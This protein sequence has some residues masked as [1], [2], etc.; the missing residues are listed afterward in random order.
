MIIQLRP[1]EYEKVGDLFAE[2]ATYH[3]FATAV[4]HH[5]LPGRI[6][7]DDANAPKSAFM[8]TKELQF[9]A[10]HPDNEAF[11]GALKQVLQQ[12]IF[13]GDG[14]EGSLAEIDLTF[15]DDSWLHR[16]ET[17]F[18]DWRWPP[19]PNQTCH[20]LFKQ[21]RLNWQTF[22]PAGYTVRPLD[23]AV[24]AN[25]PADHFQFEVKPL[26]QFGARDFG[27]CAVRH[28]QP[29]AASGRIVCLCSTDVISGSACEI[30]IETHPEH[31]RKGLATVTAAATVE[32]ALAHG[33]TA[34]WWICS[35]HNP[36]SI[37]TAEKVGFEKQF[38]SKGY[39]F[40]LDEAEHNRQ[41]HNRNE[42]KG[43]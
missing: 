9:L 8:S 6:Y 20:Y 33:F 40:L 34:I 24:I 29:E 32:Y 37:R 38:E 21:R 5:D 42:G 41:S 15:M 43:S 4:L 11:N 30:G 26:A 39:D 2:L 36:G 23:T 13:V 3:L 14:P 27:Y 7:V 1:Q 35:A 17:L 16:L 25:Q 12:T 28:G 22:V 18:G 19:I 10:G 31:Y